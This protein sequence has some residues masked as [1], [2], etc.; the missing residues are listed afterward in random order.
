MIINAHVFITTVGPN[1]GVLAGKK[2]KVHSLSSFFSRKFK[3][4][5]FNVKMALLKRWAT[6]HADW[7]GAE[8]ELLLVPVHW[9]GHWALGVIDTV[10]REICY[11]DSMANQTR[12]VEFVGNMACFANETLDDAKDTGGRLSGTPNQN[13]SQQQADFSACGV[14]VCTNAAEFVAGERQLM[15]VC[16]QAA[17]PEQR[18]AVSVTVHRFGA[19]S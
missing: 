3:N 1:E 11:L 6:K 15:S 8:T 7:T 2:S 12:H 4:N 17:V 5:R 13:I 16:V 14:F 18:K 9:P 19:A 10:R